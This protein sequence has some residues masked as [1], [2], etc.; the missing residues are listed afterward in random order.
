MQPDWYSSKNPDTYKYIFDQL[1]MGYS[2]VIVIFMLVVGDQIYT[3]CPHFLYLCLVV[4]E[5]F[6]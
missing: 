3:A 2:V 6:K 4:V 1:I 5:D